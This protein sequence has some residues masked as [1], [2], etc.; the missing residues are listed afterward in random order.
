MEDEIVAPAIITTP[1]LIEI[2][3]SNENLNI[4]NES[5]NNINNSN[6][7]QNENNK[8][9]ILPSFI[10]HVE[11]K[12][13]YQNKEIIVKIALTSDK[14]YIY[15]LSNYKDNLIYYF[16]LKISFEQL[17]KFDKVFRMCDNIDEAYNSM[18]DIF[19]AGKNTIK[20]INENKLI[21]NII[22]VNLDGKPK[23]K[24][25]ELI[26]KFKNKDIVIEN[27]SKEIVELQTKNVDLE[28]KYEL[29]KKENEK[30]KEDFIK[31]KDEIKLEMKNMNDKMTEDIKNLNDKMIQ[32][33]KNFN[34]KMKNN[35]K[36]ESESDSID[37]LIIKNKKDYDFIIQRLRKVQLN[38]D[39]SIQENNNAKISINLLYRATRDGDASSVFH[40]KC[41][42][43][44]NTL[45]AVKTKEGLRFG[46]FTCESWKGNGLDK[47]DENA[48]CYSLDKMKIYNSIKGK[49][50]IYASPD[51]GPAFE[52]CIF[53]IK[54]NCFQYG[55]Y[56]C[57]ESDKYFDNH[58]KPCEIND[59]KE[60][61]NVEEVEV[62]YVQF[63]K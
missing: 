5:N 26:K 9:D 51:F 2:N 45:V 62:F 61:F 41:D 8:N 11:Y 63:E 19:N 29:I 24:N 57:D 44:K 39:S 14:K 28:N 36:R 10:K 22:I 34:D 53:E 48:F 27:L 30:I 6:N 38:K 15:I 25:L 55:G 18:E 12:F 7:N 46:G 40:S 58:E 3:S 13:S 20:E 56:C 47:K 37:S 1:N 49:N 32:E 35:E 17:L 21:I 16:E 4:I 54:D 23:E 50:A 60:E 31:F 43:Y 59:G 52:N 42:E 33:I